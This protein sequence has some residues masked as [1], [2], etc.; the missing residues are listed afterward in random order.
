MVSVGFPV[1]IGSRFGVISKPLFALPE[2]LIKGRILQGGRGLGGKEL[3]DRYP[4]RR[5][6]AARQVVL[7]VN[8]AV[9]VALVDC[10]QAENGAGLPL[11]DVGVVAKRRLGRG[12]VENEGLPRAQDMVEH[13]FRQRSRAYP[14]VAQ[15]HNDGAGICGFR[16]DPLLDPSQTNQQ[17][18]LGAGLLDRETHESVDKLFEDELARD[19][20]RHL[21]RCREIE[22]FGRARNF[23]KLGARIQGASS[24]V[25][26]RAAPVVY[27]RNRER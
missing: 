10:G 2:R 3:Q 7:E 8:R 16:H 1:P 9:E 14:F 4:G 21:D 5:E 19:R 17:T 26:L 27:V 15:L 20:L 25:Q 23:A 13:R 24:I 18:S 22:M 11:P 6:G 12:I